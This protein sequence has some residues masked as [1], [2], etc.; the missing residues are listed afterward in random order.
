MNDR[1]QPHSIR[2][3]V[4]V[5]PFGAS[6]VCRYAVNKKYDGEFKQGSKRIFPGN[7]SNVGD[8]IPAKI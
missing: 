3:I 8:M 7:T 6:F 4:P 1:K 5:R 2:R